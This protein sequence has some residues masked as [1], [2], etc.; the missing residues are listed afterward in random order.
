VAIPLILD[1]DTGVDDA[2]AIALATRLATHKLIAVTTVAGNVN[3][4]LATGNTLRTLEY[5]EYGVPVYRGMFEPL[6]RPLHTATSV[7][8]NDGLGGWGLREASRTIEVMSAPEAIVHYAKVNKGRIDGAF[9][10]PLTNLAVALKLEPELAGWFRHVVIMGGAFFNPGNVTPH[11]EFNIFV[12]P[13]AAGTVARSELNATWIGLDVTHQTSLSRADWI[14]LEGERARP[15]TLVR[16]VSRQSFEVR[17][18]D[19]VYLHDPLAIAVISRPDL[20]ACQ[21][22]QVLVETD[23]FARGRT[24]LASGNTSS[25]AA[26]SVNSSAFRAF[27]SNLLELQVQP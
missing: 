2:M 3:V 22:G 27:F 21:A 24:R 1:V 10:G 16:E 5:L 23:H 19:Q 26:E 8:G 15:A 4:E 13:E 14:Q 11:A 7:H 20:V 9:V 17:D 25:R 18:R 12:D 6:V